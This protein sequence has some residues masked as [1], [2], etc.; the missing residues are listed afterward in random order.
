[1]NLK[2]IFI[3]SLAA[4]A[5]AFPVAAPAV[6]APVEISVGSSVVK[7]DP[8]SSQD[9][10]DDLKSQ[11]NDD[12][13][14]Y[15]NTYEL[16][17][18]GY[19]KANEIMQNGDIDQFAF[20]QLSKK[21]KEDFVS[22]VVKATDEQTNPKNN[23]YKNVGRTVPYNQTT[24]DNWFRQLQS[25]TGMGSAMLQ[26][27]FENT[28]PDWVTA[29]RIYQPFSGPINTA[30]ALVA[31]VM[32]ALLGL[33]I[34]LDLM[35]I[36]L[37]FFQEFTNSNN[38]GNGTTGKGTKRLK[39][40]TSAAQ[41]AVEDENNDGSNAMIKYMKYRALGFFLLAF[42]LLYLVMGELWSL[43]GMSLDLVSGL[44]EP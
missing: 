34:V 31:I 16:E 40:V 11:V 44:L 20:D 39:L 28:T 5:I 38:A 21:G 15:E 13:N 24:A 25:Q 42:A 26:R 36:N 37:P 33:S 43:V 8:G 32:M 27:I 9:S 7:M 22:D 29:N 41:K 12:V 23:N 1:M 14:G 6:A 4:L 30:I 2:H 3:G 35:Y 18:G 19:R 10:I 17:G